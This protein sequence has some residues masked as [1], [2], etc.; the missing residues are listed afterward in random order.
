MNNNNMNTTSNE[1]PSIALQGEILNGSMDINNVLT[2]AHNV[3]SC[4]HTHYVNMETAK[5]GIENLIVAILT[6]RMAIF[7][8]DIQ[9]TEFR[10]MAI[11][12]SLFTSEIINEVQAR[13]A[14]GSIRYPNATIH[15]YLSI[16]MTKKGKVSNIKLSNYEDAN[17]SSCKPRVKWFLV[18]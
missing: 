12:T 7:P 6:E 13:F 15:H 9:A 3:K 5:H 17:R 18:E 2:S 1:N 8:K 4:F 10:A 11:A 14:A 16:V